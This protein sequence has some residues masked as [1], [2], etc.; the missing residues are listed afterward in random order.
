MRNYLAAHFKNTL[1]QRASIKLC[2][3]LGK[4][5]QCLDSCNV[6]NEILDFVAAEGVK[7]HRSKKTSCFAENEQ[8]V[9]EKFFDRTAV[10][11]RQRE[12]H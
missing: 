10:Y 2:F 6:P 4:Q 7:Y 8:K 12:V 11:K 3:K 1:K 5:L 9:L